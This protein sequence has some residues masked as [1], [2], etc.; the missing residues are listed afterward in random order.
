MFAQEEEPKVPQLSS[1]KAKQSLIENY[2]VLYAEQPKEFAVTLAE[3]LAQLSKILARTG[4]LDEAFTASQEAAALYQNVLGI[5][6]SSDEEIVTGSSRCT[7][8][9]VEDES[10]DRTICLWDTSI[11]DVQ[12]VD[13]SEIGARIAVFPPDGTHNASGPC[14]GSISLWKVESGQELLGP[15]NSHNH[16]RSIKYLLDGRQI[17][18]GHC[19]DTT[20]PWGASTGEVQQVGRF[21]GNTSRVHPVAFSPDGTHIIS[22]STDHTIRVW[23]LPPP[24]DLFGGSTAHLHSV[25]FSP[26]GGRFVS[27]S[28]DH[29]IKVWN[30]GSPTLSPL[31]GHSGRI[32]S[33]AFSPNGTRPVSYSDD[34]SVHIWDTKSGRKLTG[35]L[36]WDT[37]PFHSLNHSP[38]D[39]RVISGSWGSTVRKWGTHVG[40][41][42]LAL[43]G[44]HPIKISQIT[45]SSNSS[46]ITSGSEGNTTNVGSVQAM[47][48]TGNVLL[49]KFKRALEAIGFDVKK[50]ESNPLIWALARLCGL[51]T[52]GDTPWF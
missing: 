45:R 42:I 10:I 2:R 28:I 16:L 49:T 50:K 14:Y 9:Y 47:Y 41:P 46:R 5:P 44:K 51:L 25:A 38:G 30:A 15:L 48:K 43:L 21:E 23:D 29:T 3:E 26:D 18:S 36:K 33:V 37:T 8:D 32:H 12:L 6:V 24:S 52:G 27:G 4:R 11:G 35:P 7:C 1:L 34:G 40:K 31:R 17:L 19:K 22:G 39:P 20:R 13:F